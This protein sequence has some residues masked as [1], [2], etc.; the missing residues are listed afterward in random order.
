MKKQINVQSID[1]ENLNMASAIEG[2]CQSN[3][4]VFITE[5]RKLIGAIW[6]LLYLPHH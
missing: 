2:I 6:E 3:G 5:Q 1:I 4:I